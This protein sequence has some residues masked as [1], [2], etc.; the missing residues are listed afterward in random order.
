MLAQ[1][2]LSGVNIVPGSALDAMMKMYYLRQNRVNMLSTIISSN[3]IK[4][5]FYSEVLVDYVEHMEF[6]VSF[7]TGPSDQSK[8]M[9]QKFRANLKKG[10]LNAK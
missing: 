2:V 9:L 7:S 5:E 3:K 10:Q 4:Q 8:K 6:S 1:G